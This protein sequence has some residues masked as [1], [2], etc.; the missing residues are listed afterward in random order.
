RTLV[1][2]LPFLPGTSYRQAVD[3]AKRRQLITYESLE[4]AHDNVDRGRR[5]GRHLV[6]P[7]RPVV[8]ERRLAGG[9]D[10]EID[11][12]EVIRRN[13]M[14]E[15]VQQFPIVVDG[16]Q[17]YLDYA[18]PQVLVYLEYDYV[19]EHE[20]YRSVFAEATD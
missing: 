14:P 13:G 9:S 16:R 6:V 18:Y 8:R 10:P 4:A 19:D 3:D 5:T 11:V 17:R 2:C 12:L 15:P 1:D 7:G 20:Q